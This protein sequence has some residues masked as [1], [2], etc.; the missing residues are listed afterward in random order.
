ME[1]QFPISFDF[2]SGQQG[3]S[4]S[5]IAEQTQAVFNGCFPVQ[6]PLSSV[7]VSDNCWQPD[8]VVLTCCRQSKAEGSATSQPCAPSLSICLSSGHRR[9]P[10]HWMA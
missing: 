5:V 8:L 9:Q 7:S 6:P 10:L 4:S 2:G 3:P 1:L